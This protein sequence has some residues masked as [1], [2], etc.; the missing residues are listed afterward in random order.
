MKLG[1]RL[2]HCIDSYRTI[3]TQRIHL[4]ILRNGYKP[5]WLWVAPWQRVVPRN[6][7]VSQKAS[8]VLNVE[9]QGLL[10][11]GAIRKA[12]PVPGQYV[13]SYFAVPKSKH[14]PDKWRPILNLKKFNNYVRHIYFQMEKIKCVRKWFQHGSMCA[15]LNIKD[16]LLHVPHECQCQEIL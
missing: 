3:G 6:P 16:A 7:K 9:V 8:D 14:V 12:S 15:G 1:E 2:A 10:E 4:D 13:S 11:K 5:P